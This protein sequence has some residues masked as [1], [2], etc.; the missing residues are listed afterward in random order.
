MIRFLFRRPRFPII[1]DVQDILIAAET[2]K[3][4]YDQI[5]SI[6][7]PAGEQIPVIDVTAEGWVLHTDLMVVSPLTLKKRWT[8]KEVIQLFNKSKT[9]KQAGLEYPLKSLSSKRFDW[10]LGDVVRL[11]LNANKQLQRARKKTARR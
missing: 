5:R 1:C 10:I 11:P 4:L 9:A 7:L 8:K 6:E 2:P 3:Q